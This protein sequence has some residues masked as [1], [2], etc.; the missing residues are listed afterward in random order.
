M[1]V[2]VDKAPRAFVHAGEAFETPGC[3]KKPL[4]RLGFINPLRALYTHT[5]THVHISNFFLTGRVGCFNL[6]TEGDLHIQRGLCEAPRN[7][8]HIEDFTHT[9]ASWSFCAERASQTPRCFTHTVGSCTH[10]HTH[11]CTFQSFSYRYGGGVP[12]MFFPRNC[13]KSTDLRTKSSS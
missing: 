4:F 12:K 2:C 10:M 13:T 11:I 8:A 6:Y 5:Y 9:G 1:Y 3:F 7:F